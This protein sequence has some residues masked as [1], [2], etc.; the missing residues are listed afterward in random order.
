MPDIGTV[1]LWSLIAAWIVLGAI[2]AAHAIMYKRDPRSATIWL[3][4]SFVFPLIGPALY[5]RLGINRIERKASRRRGR[6][7]RVF[8]A[9]GRTRSPFAKIDHN[10]V[11]HLE[12]LRKIADRVTRVPLLGG[13]RLTSLHNGEQAY[14]EML[15]AIRA[16]EKNITLE[17]YIFD[18]DD[19]GRQFADA[20]GT[21]AG[22]GVRVHILL[23]GIGAV[24]SFSRIGRRLLKSEAKVASFFP[25]GLLPFGRVRLNLRNH[26]KIMV[27]DGKTG[28]TGGMNITAKH[29]I[30]SGKPNR[31]EDMHFKVEGPVVAEMQ[32]AFVEDWYLATD[33]SLMSDDYFPD[34]EAAGETLCRGIISGPDENFE[35]IHWILKA[36]FTSAQRSVRILTPYFIP[37]SALTSAMAMAALRGVQIT[38]VIPAVLDIPLVKYASDAHLWQL[39][40]HGIRIYRRPEPFAH[41]KLMVVDDRWSLMGSANFDRR[42]FRLN[43]EF[44]LEAYDVEL[45][46]RLARGIDGVAGGL[47]PLTLRE[48]DERPLWQR[49]RDGCVRLFSPYL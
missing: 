2:S 47:T 26:R 39:L 28:F 15:A 10:I 44:N 21:A 11:G 37:T 34:L 29:L 36:A 8:D 9:E 7:S 48:V 24:G 5:W 17:S 23:D 33:E 3:F 6:R 30:S 40:E 18:W 1:V 20:L 22:R 38:L 31:I 32:E 43:F 49:F 46:Q 41:T 45:A 35:I 16:A 14:P 25:F 12:P 4:M 27:V 13:N 19:V 42:S